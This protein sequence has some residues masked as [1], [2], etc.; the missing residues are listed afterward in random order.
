MSNFMAK[1][2]QIIFWLG[3][4]QRSSM[5]TPYVDLRGLF[6][7]R[8]SVLP[9]TLLEGEGRRGR[10]EVPSTFYHGSTPMI[11]LVIHKCE[12]LARLD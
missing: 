3:S 12:H 6:K 4:L 9:N 10:G 8:S 5:Q 2:H 7:R 1:M 11:F